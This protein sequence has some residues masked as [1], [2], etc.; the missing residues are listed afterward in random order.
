MTKKVAWMRCMNHG[1]AESIDETSCIHESGCNHENSL[2]DCLMLALVDSTS[3]LLSLWLYS[4]E[5]SCQLSC[6]LS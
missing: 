1:E 4:R 5:S 6:S 2:S 3:C